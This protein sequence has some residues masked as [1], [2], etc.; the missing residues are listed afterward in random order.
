MLLGEFVE[1]LEA[2]FALQCLQMFGFEVDTVCPGKKSGEVIGDFI[3]VFWIYDFQA[4]AVHDFDGF[5]TYSEKR[6]HNFPINKDF[7]SVN[8]E[9]YAGI[10]I[11]GV[12]FFLP[13]HLINLG[14]RARVH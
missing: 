14:T 8:P 5:Q 1:G 9:D 10:Y 7:D 3:V 4:T 2:Y 13:F 12:R 11:P 6:G